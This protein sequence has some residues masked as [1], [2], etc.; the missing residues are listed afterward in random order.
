M[1]FLVIYKKIVKLLIF[2]PKNKAKI[3]DFSLEKEA[4]LRYTTRYAGVSGIF[5]LKYARKKQ[6]EKKRTC[7][8]SLQLAYE[9]QPGALGW[10]LFFY[11]SFLLQQHS[12]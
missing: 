10:D 2:P 4:I 3:A 9:V 7:V 8:L 6:K 12:S 11:Q 5:F 1:H